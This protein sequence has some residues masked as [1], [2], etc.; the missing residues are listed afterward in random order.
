MERC[1]ER[2]PSTIP[3][4]VYR[5]LDVLED[6]GVVRHAHGPNGRE[7]YHVLPDAVHG[8]LHCQ[9]CGTTSEIG[10]GEAAGI[11]GALDADRG[12]EVDLSHV[13]IAGRC[14]TC[15]SA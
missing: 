3:S 10:I 4:T 13:T 9:V 12:F 5:T 7:E 8:H 6:L 1:R 2:D 11:V 15:R 14:R